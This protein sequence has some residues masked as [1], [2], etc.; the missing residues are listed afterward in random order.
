MCAEKM[1]MASISSGPIIAL[2]EPK[3]WR[4]CNECLDAMWVSYVGPFVDPF[5]HDLASRCGT[6]FAMATSSGTTALYVALL[7]AG[8]EPGSE[9]LMPPFTSCRI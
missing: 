6:S 4:E 8:V 9:V 1:R 5:E 2:S 3:T 7:E